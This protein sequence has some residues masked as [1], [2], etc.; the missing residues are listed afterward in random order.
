MPMLTLNEVTI[1]T[2]VQRA[3]ERLEVIGDQARA[4]DGSWLETRTSEKEVFEIQTSLLSQAEG[5]A[6]KLLLEGQG[7]NWTFDV[8][9]FSTGK[10]LGPSA[11]AAA[12]TIT[13]G[14][15]FG[16][17]I[18]LAAAEQV[19]WPTGFGNPTTNDY[20]I[21]LFED[22]GAPWDRW[23]IKNIQGVVTKFL[24]GV[25]SGAATPFVSVD[26]SGDI[27]IGD[28]VGAFDIDD[29]VFV[30]FA[31]PDSW[32]VTGGGLDA[33]TRAF[34]NLP[35]LEADGDFVNNQIIEV[36]GRNV[37]IRAR[38]FSTTG[39]KYGHVISADL[40]ET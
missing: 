36:Q 23:A 27:T 16:K 17:Y 8:D 5:E 35:A 15:K 12:G 4:F 22:V 37:R 2:G 21:L 9:R 3:N 6:L 28:G 33:P 14:G 10:G 39:D 40:M 24:N 11:G 34:S 31:M 7:H 38:R 30:P 20:T 26:T 29:L 25:S 19:T 18:A 13:A 32:L 1:L